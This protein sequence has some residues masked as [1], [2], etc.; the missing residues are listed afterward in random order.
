M[1]FYLTLQLRN[2]AGALQAPN[3]QNALAHNLGLGGSCV[4]SILRRPAF[5]K[6]GTTS[7][8]RFGYDIANEVRGVSQ[9]DLAKVRSKLHSDYVPSQLEPKAAVARL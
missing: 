3:V 1:I 8:Q 4:V 5:Y 6:K 2:E 7:A 9:A